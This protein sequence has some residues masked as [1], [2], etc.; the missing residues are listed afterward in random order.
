MSAQPIT[1]GPDDDPLAPPPRSAGYVLCP[2]WIKP[3]DWVRTTPRQ[4]EVA[5]RK[6]RTMRPLTVV[7]PPAP[8]TPPR[9]DFTAE[10][11]TAAK[12]AYGRWL[13]NPKPRPPFPH[14]DAYQAYRHWRKQV[15]STGTV[16]AGHLAVASRIRERMLTRIAEARKL[17]A[18]GWTLPEAADLFGV[19]T[20]TLRKS[21]HAYRADGGHEVRD[22]LNENARR[23]S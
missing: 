3:R 22:A 23:T 19:T 13:Q 16:T 17:A 8:K 12:S 6:W 4:R 9:R 18:E 20:E 2:P 10:E 21:L 11:M 14:R 15:R 7:P 5:Y 1:N